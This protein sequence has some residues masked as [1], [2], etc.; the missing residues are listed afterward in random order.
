MTILADSCSHTEARESRKY[1]AYAKKFEDA[2]WRPF[3][4][5]FLEDTRYAGLLGRLPL[6]AHFA[7]DYMHVVSGAICCLVTGQMYNGAFGGMRMLW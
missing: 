6:C 1:T 2:G 4:Q 7:T 5:H 3:I